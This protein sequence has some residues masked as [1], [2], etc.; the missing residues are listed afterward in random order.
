MSVA[1]EIKS[2]IDIVD[3]IQK[4]VPLKRAGKM[5]KAP[6][7]FHNERTPSFVVNPDTQSWRCFGSCAEGGDV[8]SFA[9]KRNGWSFGEALQEL[10]KLTGVEVE[11]QSPEQRQNSERLDTL[12]GL[13][14]T[15]AEEYHNALVRPNANVEGQADVLRY[16]GEKRGFNDATITAFKIGYAPPGWTHML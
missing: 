6:C 9:M 15:A 3:Y 1:D 11:K 5:W 4:F 14:S 8:L 13:M 16:T 12:R 2:R 10:G 7:P